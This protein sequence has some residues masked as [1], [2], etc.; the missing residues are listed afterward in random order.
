MSAYMWK[1][2]VLVIISSP[3]FMEPHSLFYLLGFQPAATTSSC[4]QCKCSDKTI[5][6]QE[7]LQ[8]D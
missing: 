3:L 8:I 1:G 5:K 6:Q 2:M 4:F 7:H